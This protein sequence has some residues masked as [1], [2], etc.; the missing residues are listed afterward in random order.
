MKSVERNQDDKP[1]AA[2]DSGQEKLFLTDPNSSPQGEV[3]STES[4]IALCARAAVEQDPKK[5]LDLVIEINRLLDA[6][7]KRLLKETD[8][9][10]EGKTDGT[11]E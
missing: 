7:R 10:S 2:T 9:I 1:V 8:G 5:L 6:R 11:S 4:W 3:P